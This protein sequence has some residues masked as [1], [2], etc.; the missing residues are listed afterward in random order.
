MNQDV[1]GDIWGNAKPQSPPTKEE[2]APPKKPIDYTPR[3]ERKWREATERNPWP[4][5]QKKS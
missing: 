5:G 1:F 2:K 4:P 3:Q